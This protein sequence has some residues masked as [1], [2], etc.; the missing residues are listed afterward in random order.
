M[1]E[2]RVACAVITGLLA[3]AWTAGD[4]AACRVCDPWFHCVEQTPGARVCVEAPLACSMIMPCL[5]PGQRVP[6]SPEEGLMTW[7]LFDAETP[8]APRVETEAGPLALGEEARGG[9]GAGH[10]RLVEAMLAHGRDFAVMLVDALEAGFA[11]R[12][13]ESGGVA[14]VEVLEVTGGRAGRTLAGGLLG[15]RDR[16]VARVTVEGRE[17]VLVLQA[18]RLAGPARAAEVARLRRSLR[19]AARA[20]PARSRA[21]LELRA[22]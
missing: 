1:R 17:R 8:G 18:A 11:I 19:T 6:D 9:S 5:A 12:R 21:L 22:M 16:L 14:R 3:L 2:G 10:G 7:T 20:M 4:A 13:E 15:E